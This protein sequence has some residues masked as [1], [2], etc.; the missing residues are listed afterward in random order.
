MSDIKVHLLNFH[1]IW[2]HVE[3]VLENTSTN[4]H[5]FY[6]I[7]RW[8]TPRVSWSTHGPK[9][10]IEEANSIYSFHIEADPDKITKNWQKYWHETWDNASILG[11]NCSVAAQWFLTEFAGIPKP[12]LSN[13]SFNHL[14]F[15]IL[16]PSFI[17]CPVTLGGRVMSN[18][19]FHVEARNNPDIAARYTNLFLYTSIALATLA[20]ATT[21]FGL[22]VATTVLTGG[23]AALAITG[24]VIAGFASSYSFFKTYNIMSAKNISDELKKTDE[25]TYLK[26]ESNAQQE[27]LE[28]TMV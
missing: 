4:P 1:G 25:L 12:S 19:K 8:E 21:V 5:T 28:L 20:L 17:P 23:I 15:G 16:W 13:I 3:I 14:A 7:N 9:Y 24:C 27:P 26:N 11:E 22:A 10:N 2:S 18:A 6:G